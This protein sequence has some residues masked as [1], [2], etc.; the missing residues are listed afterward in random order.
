MC[1]A[2]V[3]PLL[4]TGV[5]RTVY[6]PVRDQY[7]CSMAEVKVWLKGLHEVAGRGE[8][9]AA[10]GDIGCPAGSANSAGAAGPGCPGLAGS[11]SCL[12]DLEDTFGTAMVTA[13][14]ECPGTV[15]CDCLSRVT[16]ILGSP[17]AGA[18][19]SSWWWASAVQWQALDQVECLARCLGGCE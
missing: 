16:G 12:V 18:A 15:T 3:V 5:K 11:C 13:E 8:N 4:R 1:L 2:L 19:A 6:C 17:V 9:D 7:H 14:V 10:E